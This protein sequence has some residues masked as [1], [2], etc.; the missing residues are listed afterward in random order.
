MKCFAALEI[1]LGLAKFTCCLMW[2]AAG[3]LHAESEPLPYH[4]IRF[5]A[6]ELLL[7]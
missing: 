6:K 4:F 2:A 7:G 5:I 3:V 1:A